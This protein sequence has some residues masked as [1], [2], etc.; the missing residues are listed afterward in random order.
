MSEVSVEERNPPG[1]LLLGLSAVVTTGVSFVAWLLIAL[2]T[3]FSWLW[4]SEWIYTG[5]ALPAAS[6][7]AIAAHMTRRSRY[8]WLGLAIT[9]IPLVAYIG[10]DLTAPPPPPGWND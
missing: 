6:V 5:L 9:L 4:G 2:G 7:G 3:V 10:L 1:G 8:F